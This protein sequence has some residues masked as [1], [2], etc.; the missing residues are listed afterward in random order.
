MYVHVVE[1]RADGIVVCGA[2][3][4]TR[5]APSTPTGNIFMPTISM[6]PDDKGLAV[7]FACPTDA[8]GMYMIYGRQSCDTRK[9]EEN[10]DID[11]G[12]KAFGG[13]GG[14]GGSGPCVHPQRVYLPERRVRVCRY[15][16]GA[17]RR[18]SPSE[19]RRL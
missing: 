6:G 15:D 11:L 16:G 13:Q 17:V 18:V 1:R 7:S 5:R 14:P 12:N 3:S 19:L 10:A 8:E 9:M 2:K 4:A